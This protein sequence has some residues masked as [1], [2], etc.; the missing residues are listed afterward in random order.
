[1]P[2]KAV[3]GIAHHR[4]YAR[5]KPPELGAGRGC[6]DC[7]LE[8]LWAHGELGARKAAWGRSV[9]CGAGPGKASRATVP[10]AGENKCRQCPCS[11]AW[12]AK[13]S[14]QGSKPFPPT[15]FL[16][17]HPLTELT[18]PASKGEI[19]NGPRCIFEEQAKRLNVEL[20]SNQGCPPCRQRATC[21]PGLL[22]MWPNTKS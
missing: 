9:C 8:K 15:T 18:M 3:H 16:Q 11:G 17:C 12:A 21:S 19:F 10:D 14:E 22:W 13:T 2:R 7:S 20:R 1:M 4:K 6:E 5:A